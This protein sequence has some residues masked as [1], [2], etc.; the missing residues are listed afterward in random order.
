MRLLFFATLDTVLFCQ[1]LLRQLRIFYPAMPFGRIMSI[2]GVTYG[3]GSAAGA[4]VSGLFFDLTGSYLIPFTR[5]LLFLCMSAAAIWIPIPRR[6]K[7]YGI[8]IREEGT[9]N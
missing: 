3:V 9:G 6:E 2:Q 5:R 4:Y 7:G 1:S 8:F